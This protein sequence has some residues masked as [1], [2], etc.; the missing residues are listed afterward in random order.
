VDH[1]F[2]SRDLSYSK[3][4]AVT[5]VATPETQ[6]E[7]CEIARHIPAGELRYALS[8]WL[9]RRETPAE[10]EERQ[11][12]CRSFHAQLEPDGMGVGWFRLPPLEF[13]RLLSA[14]DPR[15]RV[16]RPRAS[17]DASC[18]RPRWPSIAQQR[19]DALVELAC[20]DGGGAIGTEVVFHVRGDGCTL[21]DGTPIAESVVERIAPRAFLRALIH[22][23]EGR[24]INA[25]SRRRH[26]SM[27]QQRVTD[28][29]EPR[30]ADCGSTEFLEYDHV[31][32]FEQ[33]GQTV[34]EELRRRCMWCHHRRHR[35]GP[36]P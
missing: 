6:D 9:S 1:A 25:S 33:S 12:G 29:R 2:A 30:C 14:I 34:V 27:R 21:D 32:E 7:L 20:D 11:H 5:R 4:R 19:A 10:T 8:A 35:G 26:P 17:A 22:D 15:V 28:E 18:A 36:Q 23:A 3:V 13:G 24:P 31:P 16:S